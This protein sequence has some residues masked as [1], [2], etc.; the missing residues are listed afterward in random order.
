MSA[1]ET[2]ASDAQRQFL[3]FSL[4]GEEYGVDILRVQEIRAWTPVTSLPHARRWVRGVLDL[5]GTVVPVIDLRERLDMEAIG[6]GSTTVVVVVRA[7]EGERERLAGLVV[8]GV[9][10]V[11]RITNDEIKDRP[12]LGTSI[13]VRYMLGLATVGERMAI[14]L[15]VDKLILDAGTGLPAVEG[16]DST[17]EADR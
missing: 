10:D 2:R 6:Y 9:S 15:D 16:I 13:D 5:R 11:C 7:G 4:A 3:T 14:L 17:G 8:D 12:E 1:I